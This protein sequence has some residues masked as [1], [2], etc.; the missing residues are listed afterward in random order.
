EDVTPEKVVEI[1]EK[2]RKGEKPPVR[3]LP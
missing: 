2:L 3:I 1:V